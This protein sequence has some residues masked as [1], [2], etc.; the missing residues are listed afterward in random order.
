MSTRITYRAWGLFARRAL[1]EAR[2]EA[3]RLDNLL[4]RFDAGS[5]VSRLNR[6]SAANWVSLSPE[7]LSVLSLAEKI[8]ILS[9]GAFDIRVGSLCDLWNFRSAP[10]PPDGMQIQR[11][12]PSAGNLQLDVSKSMAR[13]TASDLKIDLGGIAKGYAADCIIGV[14]REHHVKSAFTSIGGNVSVLGRRPDGRP[15]SVG[16]R[17]PREAGRLLGAIQAQ[18]CSVVTSGDYERCFAGPD[19]HRYH[20]LLNPATGKPADS[21]LISVTVMAGS[22]A[23]ADVLSTAVFVL[24]LEKGMM[25]IRRFEGISALLVDSNLTVFVSEHLVGNYSPSGNGAYTVLRPEKEKVSG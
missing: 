15:W 2:K 4:S 7:T 5:E 6:S 21:G 25:L 11:A 19:G 14:L 9:G 16:I 24:G 23:L 10:Q 1:N 18:N 20:H 8:H 12:L 13:L 22:S 3:E 17:H